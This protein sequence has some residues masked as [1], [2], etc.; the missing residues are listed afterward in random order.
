MRTLVVSV[1][2][3]SW[4][5]GSLACS[6]AQDASPEPGVAGA[7]ATVRGITQV[8]PPVDIVTPPADAAKTTSGL[9]Y[10][11]LITNAAGAQPRPSDTVLIRYTGW[12]RT[13]ETFFTTRGRDQPIAVDIAHSTPAFG[14]VLP[15]LHEGETAML[16]VPPSPGMP[17]PLVYELE[18]VHV[19]SPPVVANR[20]AKSEPTPSQPTR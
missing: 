5:F 1:L 4:V 11:R 17:S 20:T 18:V 6:G 14:E 16:W 12:R 15:L 10:K 2:F 7:S 3:S 19:V 13:G 8:S 9:V